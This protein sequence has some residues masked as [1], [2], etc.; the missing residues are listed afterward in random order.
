MSGL[1]AGGKYDSPEINGL[2]PV[3]RGMGPQAHPLQEI[4]GA[5]VAE[6]VELMSTAEVVGADGF[7]FDTSLPVRVSAKPGSVLVQTYDR[8]VWETIY[9]TPFAVEVQV[10]NW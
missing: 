2:A 10:R 3:P 4:A 6:V 8:G 1:T 5:A 7:K 9:E